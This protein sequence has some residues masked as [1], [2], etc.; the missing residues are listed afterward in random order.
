MSTA[1]R[2]LDAAFLACL[3]GSPADHSRPV[4]RAYQLDSSQLKG[5]LHAPRDA[6]WLLGTRAPLGR[7]AQA[8]PGGRVARVRLRLVGGGVW[9]GCGDGA[10]LA[11]RADREDQARLGDL[12]DA[13]PLPRDDRDDGGHA[14]PAV[15]R[16]HAAGDRLVG[17]AGG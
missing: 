4:R 15:E 17:T 14:G 12:P 11:R 7:A 3:I 13:R 6:H 5:T 8:R 1:A 2:S 10:G 9:L 16:A